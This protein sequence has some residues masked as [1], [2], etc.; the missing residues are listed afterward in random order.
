ME[1]KVVWF[2]NWLKIIETPKGFF[3]TERKGKNS[4]AVFLVRMNP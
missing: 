2:N 1:S 4:I 3:Y